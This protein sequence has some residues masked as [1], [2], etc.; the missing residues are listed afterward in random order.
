MVDAATL[1]RLAN[2]LRSAIEVCDEAL[3]PLLARMPSGGWVGKARAVILTFRNELVAVQ[4]ELGPLDSADDI[5]TVRPPST[6]AMQAVHVPK[7]E[8]V[9]FPEKGR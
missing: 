7:V 9:R 8:V 1:K 4:S 5:P 6:P 3:L 2:R